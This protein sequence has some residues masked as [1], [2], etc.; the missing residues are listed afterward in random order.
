MVRVQ[1]NTPA[2]SNAPTR[3]AARAAQQRRRS[4]ILLGVVVVLVVALVVALGV[5]FTRGSADEPE[6]LPV[7]AADCPVA[8]LRITADPALSASRAAAVGSVAAK[9]T[10]VLATVSPT[11]RSAASTPVSSA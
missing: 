9:T 4:L 5:F 3:A 6:Q 8:G 7:T 10:G 2:S 1:P 11:T